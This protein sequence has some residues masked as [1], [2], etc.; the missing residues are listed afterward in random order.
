MLNNEQIEYILENPKEIARSSRA[1]FAN[2]YLGLETP[3]HQLDWYDELFKYNHEYLLS[4]RDHGKTTVLPRVITE[5]DCLFQQDFLTLI[6]SKTVGQSKKSL[7]VIDKDLTKNQYIQEDFQDELSDY[8]KIGNEIY[9]NRMKV[10]RDATIEGNGLLGNITGGHFH[11][12]VLDDVIDD[13]N[14]RTKSARE[15]AY[16]WIVGTILPLLEP[17]GRIIGIGTRK[18]YEDAYNEMIKNPVWYVIIQ[19]AII[20]KPSNY[21]IVFD[22]NNIA[23]DVINITNDFEVLWPEKWDIRRLL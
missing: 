15:N 21:E 16:K 6:I 11:R 9:F 20:K 4:P 13:E 14:T 5:H 1:F 22:E 19:Q 12:I 10:A 2:Y 17:D 7:N 18:H 3:Q 23:V 8:D